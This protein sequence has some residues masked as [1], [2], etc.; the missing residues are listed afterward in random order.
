MHRKNTDN[1]KLPP[2]LKIA[3]SPLVAWGMGH[4]LIRTLHFSREK[5]L[6][7]TLHFSRDKEL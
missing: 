5:E 4:Q 7:R 6:I 2:L 3:Q 1:L